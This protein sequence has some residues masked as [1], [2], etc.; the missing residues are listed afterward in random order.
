MQGRAELNFSCWSEYGSEKQLTLLS[1][2]GVRARAGSMPPA[3]YLLLHPGNKLSAAESMIIYTWT[4]T[5]QRRLRSPAEE[6]K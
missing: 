5:E 2:V 3:R 6:T 1:E 4:K